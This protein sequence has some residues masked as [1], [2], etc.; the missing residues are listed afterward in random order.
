MG[1]CAA[2]T[3]CIMIEQYLLKRKI[4]FTASA[5]FVYWYGRF[6]EGIENINEDTGITLE[7][8]L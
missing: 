2:M 5:L 3:T 6:C 8:A 4:K 1:S 7:D